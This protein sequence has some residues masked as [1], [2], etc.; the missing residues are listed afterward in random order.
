MIRNSKKKYKESRLVKE[1]KTKNQVTRHASRRYFSNQTH[2]A[3]KEHELESFYHRLHMS[4][5][6]SLLRLKTKN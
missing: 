3:I 4:Q 1:K 6:N 2:D 5:Y